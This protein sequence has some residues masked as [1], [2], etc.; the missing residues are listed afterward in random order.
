MEQV[1]E[2]GSWVIGGLGIYMMI[3][4]TVGWW[5][6][7]RVEN[8]ADFLVAGR[9][10]GVPLMI[11]ALVATWYGAGT[12]MG[13]AGAT[14]LFGTQGVVF[15]PYGAAL[16]LVLLGLFFARVVRRSKFM[17]LV[18]FFESRFD[19]RVAGVSAFV[20]LIA[21]MGWIGALL[22]GFGSIFQ[23]FTGVPLEW[24]IGVSTLVLI[25]Y[26]FM[27]GMYAITL[28]DTVQM[29]V[30]TVS[31]VISMTL[32]GFSGACIPMIL[33]TLRQDPAQSS[34]IILTTVTDVVGFF[35]FLGIATALSSML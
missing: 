23:F 4:L 27:G 5:A 6:S 21:E 11:G 2:Y 15:D 18:D 7:K 24:G 22:V 26:T 20:M 17:T 12:T 33:T 9:R 16:C 13:A 10:L 29:T 32:A 34:S 25:I 31:M 3:L 1:Y 8:E 28:T 19:R 14:Y 35:S 30:I